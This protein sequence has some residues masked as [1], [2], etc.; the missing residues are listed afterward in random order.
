MAITFKGPIVG[1]G[2]K[3]TGN[4]S[5]T[6][7]TGYATGDVVVVWTARDPGNSTGVDGAF[8][9]GASTVTDN[10]VGGS[11]SYVRAAS[12]RAIA[13]TASAG[14]IVESVSYTHLTLPTSDLV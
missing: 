2:L 5:V 11:N 4:P 6:L 7:T 1:T 12:Y 10:A 9:T 14:V 13:G 3:T 8:T